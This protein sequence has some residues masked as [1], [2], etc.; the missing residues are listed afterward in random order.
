[1]PNLEGKVAIVTGG[2]TGLGYFTVRDLM[3]KN[4]K[5]F[6][7]SRTPSKGEAACKKLEAEVKAAGAT[8]SVTFIKC[9]LGSLQSVKDSAEEFAA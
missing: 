3:L 9:D 8:G 2:N 4:A 6:M 1:M 7:F 5:V